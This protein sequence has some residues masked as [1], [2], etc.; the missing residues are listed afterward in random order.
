MEFSRRRLLGAV[1][2]GSAGLFAPRAFAAVV[3]GFQPD[4]LPRAIAALDAHRS[5]VVNRDLIGIVD[6][7]SHSRL[8]RFHLVDIAN[9]RIDASLLVAHGRGSDPV[10]SGFVQKFS[11]RPGSNASS[12]GS[13]LTGDTYTGRHGRSRRLIG[14]DPENSEAWSRAIVIHGANYVD[15]GLAEAQG[16]IGRSQGCFAFSYRDIGDVLRRIGPGHLIYASK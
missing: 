10:N 4:L 13:F 9:G 12:S 16:R 11:N 8:P 2:A 3:T 5:K 6:F 1:A 7:S 15:P 14:L